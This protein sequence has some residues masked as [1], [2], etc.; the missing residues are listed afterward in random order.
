MDPLSLLKSATNA[1][2]KNLT[3]GFDKKD[4]AKSLAAVTYLSMDNKGIEYI[5]NLDMCTNIA[6]L[7]LSENRIKTLEGAFIGHGYR[8]LVQITLDDN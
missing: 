5:E 1:R 8:N 7:Y 4:P 2:Y 3:D 6:C